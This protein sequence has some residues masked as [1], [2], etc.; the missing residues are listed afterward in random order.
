METT[1]HFVL[2]FQK[3][4]LSWDRKLLGFLHLLQGTICRAILIWT[5]GRLADVRALAN[6]DPNKLINLS[7][8]PRKPFKVMV[9]SAESRLSVCHMFYVI[10]SLS[11]VC[12]TVV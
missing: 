12:L 10:M 11:P 5:P 9:K 6:G 8:K 3:S 1:I 7:S 4:E 2:L